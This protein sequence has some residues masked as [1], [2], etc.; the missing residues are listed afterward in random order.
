MP[1]GLE[2]YFKK[3]QKQLSVMLLT[4]QVNG[5]TKVN[6]LQKSKVLYGMCNIQQ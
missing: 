4:L 2:A 5:S 6:Q 3:R 1:L